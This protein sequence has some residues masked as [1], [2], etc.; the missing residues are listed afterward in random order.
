[1]HHRDLENY[2]GD[3]KRGLAASPKENNTSLLLLASEALK[4]F[5]RNSY[6][7]RKN[8]QS[9]VWA[10]RGFGGFY[11]LIVMDGYK[12]IDING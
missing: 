11:E 10:N 5:G 6:S 1:M 3:E 9:Q 12:W 8:H 7:E 4:F 2:T